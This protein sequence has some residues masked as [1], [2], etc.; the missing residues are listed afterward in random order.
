MNATNADTVARSEP[1]EGPLMDLDFIARH[2]IVERYLA[3]KLPPR[4]VRD[5]EGFCGRHPELLDSIGLSAQVNA[6]LRLLEAGGKPEPWTPK[7]AAFYQRPVLVAL[8]AVAT[9]AL[10]VATALLGTRYSGAQARIQALRHQLADH[11]LGAVTSTQSVPVAPNRTA[12]SRR[13]VATLHNDIAQLA[14]LKVDVSWSP[15]SN[16]RVLIDRID[17][18]RF[19]VIGNLLRD[20]NGQLQLG[21]NTSALGPGDYQLTIEGLDWRGAAQP[22]GW[23]TITVTP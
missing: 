15:Y 21:L 1:A 20:S 14:E 22:Q 10:L 13:P 19:M 2:Q 23:A 12:P 9:L 11:P 8:L 7:K 3:G 4:G 6:A 16:F 17:Q 5:F 18:G